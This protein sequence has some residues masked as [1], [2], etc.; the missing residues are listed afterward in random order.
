[1]TPEQTVL[2]RCADDPFFFASEVLGID[3][4]TPNQK[5]LIE[6]FRSNRYT[7]SPAAFGVGKTFVAAFLVT[8]FLYT[9][10]RSKVITT[11]PSWF[12][13]ENLLWREVRSMH[14]KARFPLGGKLL[15]TQLE[16]DDQ[17]VAFGLSTTD[18]TR[19]NGSH[20]ERVA[21]FMDEATG[22]PTWVWDGVKNITVGEND[23]ILAIGNPT[24]PTSPFKAACDSG[25]WNVV[26]IS[27]ED[28]PNVVSGRIVVPGA[29]TRQWLADC[30]EDAGGRDTSLYRC[31]ALGK[32]PD[33]GDDVLIPLALVEAAQERAEAI[34]AD[35]EDSRSSAVVA[36][37][38]DVA[39]YGSDE[40]VTFCVDERGVVAPAIVRRGQNLMATAGHLKAIGGDQI[41][42]DDTGLGG[43]VSDRLMEE[44]VFFTPVNFSESANDPEKFANRRA[45]IW[46]ALRE[47]LRAGLLHLPRDRRLAG[48]LTSLRYAYDGRG[49][50]KLES[51]DE[52]RKRIGRS[53][54]RGDALALAAVAFQAGRRIVLKRES[55]RVG[56][57]ALGEIESCDWVSA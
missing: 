1:M 50:I 26:E 51:K 38:C 24:D 37:G 44:R 23:R 29:V 20:A 30:L 25:R 43:G 19:F 36:T 53:P 47:S 22:V 55:L 2:R 14:A 27:A 45:E 52:V 4:F 7:A 10:P 57:S 49:R 39:R 41:F 3:Y 28:H 15:A 9:N 46:W 18:Q 40:T 34:E 32:W 16:I 35:P 31:K 5:E 13:V 17:W 6:S 48:D 11:A 21:V 54:D 33:A 8:Q 42:V 12:Q 56:G